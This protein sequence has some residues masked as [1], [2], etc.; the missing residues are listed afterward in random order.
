MHQAVDAVLD[1]RVRLQRRRSRWPQALSSV[2]LH[3]G[4]TLAAVLAP[5]LA[6]RHR[7]HPRFVDVTIV[8]VQALGVEDPTTAE[9]ARTTEAAPER[10]V[11]HLEAEVETAPAMTLPTPEHRRTQEPPPATPEPRPTKPAPR[12]APPPVEPAPSPAVGSGVPGARKGSAEG[13]AEGTSPF[14]A[15]V[16]GLDNPDFTYG[17]YVDQMLSMIRS[18]WLRPPLGDDT[19]AMIH[20][21]IHTDGSVSEVRIVRSSGYNQF[22]LAGLRAIEAAAPFPPLPRSYRRDSLGVN[23][24]FR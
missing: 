3:A 2:L 6:A 5:M 22:D 8:P 1:R 9:A 13:L 24:I 14:G 10:P 12:S 23:L 15:A 11:A 4:L 20:F 19:E 7:E 18:R 21:R 17:Y 16:A